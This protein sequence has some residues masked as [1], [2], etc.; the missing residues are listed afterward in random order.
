M[1]KFAPLLP[2]DALVKIYPSYTHEDVFRFETKFAYS[3]LIMNRTEASI[4][5]T[6]NQ[7]RRQIQKKP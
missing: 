5:E 1:D 6:A 3:L 4:Q 2:V 7:T